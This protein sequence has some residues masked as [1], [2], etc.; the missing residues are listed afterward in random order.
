M[1]KFFVNLNG[2]LDYGKENI[3]T[4]VVNNDYGKTRRPLAV[5]FMEKRP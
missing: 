5:I 2:K 3:I 1:D 4:V